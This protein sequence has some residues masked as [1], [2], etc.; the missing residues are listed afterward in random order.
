LAVG[1]LTA[2]VATATGFGVNAH[3]PSEAIVERIDDA[4]IGWV[5]IDFLWR[6]VEPERDVYDW[7]TYDAL[8]DRLEARGLR[9]YAGIGATPA[10]A[11]SG[12]EFS[13]VP[14][15]VDQWRELCYLAAR[16]YAG[17]VHAW[18]MW[19]EPNLDRFWDGTRRE[20]ID[21]ILI[22]GADAIRLG[23]PGA[24]VAAPDLAQLSSADW[25]DWLDAVIRSADDR[26]DIVTHHIYPADGWAWQ[27]SEALDTDDGLPFTDPPVNDVLQDTGWWGRPFWLTETGVESARW[28]EGRQ[29]LFV[30]RL[31]DDWYSPDRAHRDWVDRIFFYEMADGASPSPY[32]FGLV[33]GPPDLTPKEGFV[34]YSSFISSAEVDDAELTFPQPVPRFFVPGEKTE[35]GVRA[36]NTGT[37]DWSADDGVRLTVEIES[38]TWSVEVEQLR[39]NEIVEPGAEHE[40]TVRVT[41]PPAPLKVTFSYPLMVVRMERLDRWRFGD[42]HRSEVVYAGIEPPSVDVQ[43]EPLVLARS[44]A[45]TLEIVAGGREPLTYRWLRNGVELSDDG[46]Y[47]GSETPTLTI[48]AIDGSVEAFYQCRVG[49]IIDEVVSEAAWVEFG[50]PAPRPTGGR[51]TPIGTPRGIPGGQR[52]RLTGP[53][54]PAP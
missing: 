35:F 33:Y 44:A 1:L 27:V 52:L 38:P 45:G 42:E 29:A 46:R 12:P 28:G 8:L 39:D 34:A 2:Q 22:P 11:T 4:G 25:D 47:S 14:D 53:P 50:Q 5:R 13:G 30:D 15:D 7:S 24:R 40:F 10:W 41:P 16:R 51:V 3:V 21:L 32:T 20:Y 9:V 26:I 43:P 48:H 6:V 31:L 18:G 17:R 19:N 54:P 23:D 37:T 36:L 49:N